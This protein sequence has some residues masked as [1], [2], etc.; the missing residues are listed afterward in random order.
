MSIT[1][2]S[3]NGVD[4]ISYATIA[5]IDNY[6]AVD[7][8]RA[9]AWAA[10]SATQKI[11]RAIAA[12]RRLDLLDYSGTKTGGRTQVNE[13]PRTNATCNGV[14]IGTT[15][16]VPIEIENAT[17]L[18][19]GSI[20]LDN[21]TAGAGTSG[22]NIERVQAGSASVT[23]FS[24]QP[25]VALQDETAFALVQCLLASDISVLGRSSFGLA[26]GVTGDNSETAFGDRDSPDVTEGYP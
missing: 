25:G 18:L 21:T 3:L 22:S 19:A 15:T 4:Y 12:T 16:D 26:S 2:L 14:D 10:L 5:Q 20:E 17:A 8:T 13:W 7:P 6:L 23:F 1:T 24:P 9:A 11:Q